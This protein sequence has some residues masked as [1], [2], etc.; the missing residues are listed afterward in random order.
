MHPHPP[1]SPCRLA[2]FAQGLERKVIFLIFLKTSE[3]VKSVLWCAGGKRTT[4]IIIDRARRS[5]SMCENK[6]F[7]DLHG[8]SKM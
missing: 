4:G 8:L 5:E 2:G 7:Y 6:W 1:P 3:N